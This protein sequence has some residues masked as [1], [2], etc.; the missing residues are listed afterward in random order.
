MNQLAV[1]TGNQEADRL[2]AMASG[3]SGG[4][5]QIRVPFLGIQYRPVDKLKREVRAGRFRIPD[6]DGENVYLKSPKIRILG[7]YFQYRES[8]QEGKLLCKS[9][10]MPTPFAEPRDQKGGIRCGRP[11]SKAMKLL[12]DDDAAAWRKKVPFVRIVRG[13]LSGKG[14]DA[15]GN[16]R[17]LENYP[18]QLHLKGLNF[19]PY[20]NKV[21]KALPKSKNAA[22]V[23][24]DLSS[25]LDGSVWLID[26]EVDHNTDAPVDESIIETVKVFGMMMEQ[27]NSQIESM[28]IEG[29]AQRNASDASIESTAEYL[30]PD[31]A[32]EIEEAS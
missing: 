17:V 2:L 31:P 10:L 24:L 8:D 20:E 27:E 22:T 30:D 26:F 23:W 28:H 4:T 15:D 19:M 6:T 16:E 3:G 25:R 1:S 7:E 18:F 5:D 14:E 12:E 11:D 32:L 29:I 13:V 21:K 9:I